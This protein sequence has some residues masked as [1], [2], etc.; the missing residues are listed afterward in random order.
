ME[1]MA[2]VTDRRQGRRHD[3]RLRRVS[4]IWALLVFNVLTPGQCF[5]SAHPAPDR[6]THHPGHVVRGSRAGPEH[7][8]SDANAAE[9]VPRA[10]HRARYRLAHD[11]RSPRWSRD[12]IP[13][14]PPD[15]FSLRAVAPHPMVGQAG[16]DHS[17]QSRARHFAPFGLGRCGTLHRT[18]KSH[19][20]VA[21]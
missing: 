15:R 9:L 3:S 12:R 16:P 20:R 8:S 13:K 21:V 5:S 10:L 11:E 6:P 18:R 19:G 14:P 2:A 7:Q 4:I 1:T 17:A